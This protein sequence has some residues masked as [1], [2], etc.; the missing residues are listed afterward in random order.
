MLGFICAFRTNRPIL[1]PCPALQI[2]AEHGWRV[3]LYF[4]MIGVNVNKNCLSVY[5]LMY[6]LPLIITTP[7]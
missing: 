4:I 7:L 5:L 3:N 1:Q 6:F 2:V